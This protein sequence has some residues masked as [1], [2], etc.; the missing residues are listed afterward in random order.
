[1]KKPTPGRLPAVV[2][3]NPKYAHNVGA[4]VRACSCWGVRQ[5]VEATA[6]PWTCPVASGCHAR[7][8]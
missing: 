8:E 6:S 1:M 4:A 2:L 5:L 3:I 7:S